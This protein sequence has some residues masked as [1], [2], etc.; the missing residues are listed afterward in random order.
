MGSDPSLESLVR[1]LSPVRRRRS[2]WF[3][4]LLPDQRHV[5]Y[6]QRLRIRV[7]GTV[8]GHAPIRHC[9]ELYVPRARVNN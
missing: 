4:L 2:T 9:L 1:P 5:L 8:R 7:S 3:T 6:G